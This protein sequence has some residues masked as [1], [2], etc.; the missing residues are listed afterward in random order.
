MLQEEYDIAEICLNGHVINDSVQSL[1]QRREDFCQICGK[2]TITECQQCRNKIR[3]AFWGGGYIGTAE[4]RAP[5]YCYKCGKPFPWV[6][7]KIKAATE[8][9]KEIGGL[10]DNEAADLSDNIFNIISETSKT[11]I[12]AFRF[13]KIMAK[14]G[15]ETA[16]AIRDIVVDIASETAKKIIWKQ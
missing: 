4:F 11:Q 12:G 3:G 1:P 6:E 16:N 14:V 8:I 13:K 10:S 5:S 15:K 7:D 9:A 2:K